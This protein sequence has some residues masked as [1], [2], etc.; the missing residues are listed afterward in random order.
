[1]QR[2]S[3]N[4]TLQVI[5]KDVNEA[6]YELESLEVGYKIGRKIVGNEL[7]LGDQQDT[8]LQAIRFK[9]GI[10]QNHLMIKLGM[11]KGNGSR[12][13][14]QLCKDGLIYKDKNGLWP[15]QP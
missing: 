15:N 3:D 10:S 5:G 8:L 12:R 13:V 1:M 2:D 6:T 4:V 7:K 14:T 11:D 9:P